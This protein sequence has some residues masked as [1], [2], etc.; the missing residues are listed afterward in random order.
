LSVDFPPMIAKGL[1][2]LAG[3]ATPVALL[4]IGAGF[5]GAK[6]I[7]K[8]GPTCA[9]TFIKLVLLPVIFLPIAAWMGFRDQ[10]MVALVIL[11]GAPST[12]SGYVMAKN[13]GGDHVLSASIVV[14]ST[15]L[16]AVTL[17]VTL[18]ILRTMGLI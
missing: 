4:S 17:T 6:A 7:K 15:A 16:S 1:D 3:C 2:M 10:A 12:V 5:E 11:C 8:L 14:L 18:F 13:M 9:A